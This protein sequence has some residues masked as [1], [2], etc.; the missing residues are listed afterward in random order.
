MGHGASTFF[1]GFG[2]ALETGVNDIGDSAFWKKGVLPVTHDIGEIFQGSSGTTVGGDDPHG[3]GAQG[4]TPGYG[5]PSVAPTVNQFTMPK[6]F[7]D[8]Q[9]TLQRGTADPSSTS[10]NST[11]RFGIA[12][13]V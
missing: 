10:H 6:N 12:S 2:D 4:T 3:G 9:S 8:R 11:A 5:K 7:T 1:Q 13:H